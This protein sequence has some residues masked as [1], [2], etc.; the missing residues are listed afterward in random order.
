MDD[1]VLHSGNKCQH[2][3]ISTD[4]P[5]DIK[6]SAFLIEPARYAAQQIAI[7]SMH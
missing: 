5:S 6:F 3:H 2:E 1:L 4:M 7:L